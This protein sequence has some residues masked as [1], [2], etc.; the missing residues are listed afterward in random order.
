MKILLVE[1]DIDLNETIKEYLQNYYEIESAFDGEEAL[2]KA[3]ENNYDVM[4]FDVKLPK[5]DGLS[6]VKEIRK[7]KH[8][9][10]IFLTE[11]YLKFCV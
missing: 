1:D 11:T 7:F 3:Y 4:I 9:P 2:K 6:A 8:A 5:M 10:V